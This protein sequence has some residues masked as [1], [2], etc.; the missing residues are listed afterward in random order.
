M[1][2]DDDMEWAKCI[3]SNI[4][5]EV[6]FMIQGVKD[7]FTILTAN[8]SENQSAFYHWLQYPI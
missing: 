6:M 3:F 7:T 1:Y 2:F 4:L 8:H 5:D